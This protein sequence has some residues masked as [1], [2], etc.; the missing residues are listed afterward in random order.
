MTGGSDPEDSDLRAAHVRSP[1]NRADLSK[2][3]PCGCFHLNEQCWHRAR[4]ATRR[5][6]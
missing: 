6:R 3:G 5:W 1:G 2:G 4:G